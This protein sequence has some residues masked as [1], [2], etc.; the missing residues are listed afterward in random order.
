MGIPTSEVIT[1]LPQPGGGP[2]TLYGH[3]V[4]LEKKEEETKLTH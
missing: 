2:R 1:L 4:A 3:V